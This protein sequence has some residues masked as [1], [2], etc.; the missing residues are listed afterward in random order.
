MTTQEESVNQRWKNLQRRSSLQKLYQLCD[1][2]CRI[3][4]DFFP[5]I[6]EFQV[7]CCG[8]IRKAIAFLKCLPSIKLGLYVSFC[9]LSA[10]ILCCLLFTLRINITY[11]ITFLFGC[12]TVLGVLAFT[13]F[14]VGIN[15][16][17]KK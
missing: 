2:G 7:S 3:F 17:R 15:R 8:D 1:R 5:M 12:V 13:I 9:L 4:P 16:K 6:Q 11:G 10:E 14:E